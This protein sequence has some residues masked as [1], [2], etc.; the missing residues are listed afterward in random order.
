M[1]AKITDVHDPDQCLHMVGAF[2]DSARRSLKKGRP[3]AA[4]QSIS[5]AQGWHRRAEQLRTS[6]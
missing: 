5:R 4:A 3:D 6:R 1:T 2:M